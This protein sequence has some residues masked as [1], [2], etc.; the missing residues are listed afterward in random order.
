[1]Q[2]EKKEQCTECKYEIVF[3]YIFRY[4]NYI[5]ASLKIC[6]YAPARASES[7][8]SGEDLGGAR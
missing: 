3:L 8:P 1:M 2:L 7:P 6:I 5:Q 4:K